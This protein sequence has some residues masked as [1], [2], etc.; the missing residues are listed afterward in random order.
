[1][2]RCDVIWFERPI[3]KTLATFYFGKKM[4]AWNI[5]LEL[6]VDREFNLD[7]KKYFTHQMWL[8]LSQTKL[9]D[10]WV[11]HAGFGR[12]LGPSV[13]IFALWIEPEE[14]S[15]MGFIHNK[16]IYLNL[17]LMKRNVR[18]LCDRGRNKT[19]IWIIDHLIKLAKTLQKTCF[20]VARR[21]TL[22]VGFSFL[23]RNFWEGQGSMNAILS[24]YD[25]R[26]SG[27]ETQTYL[28]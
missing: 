11:Y 2:Q 21:I 16:R 12:G 6:I 27:G 10:D 15:S 17:Q 1:M 4:L 8:N 3:A 22:A 7:N 19:I 23:P 28:L 13:I 14:V 5:K 26:L 9:W 20:L 24:L 25:C 18:S